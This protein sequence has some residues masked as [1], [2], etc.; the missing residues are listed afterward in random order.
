MVLY[1][2]IYFSGI[3]ALFCITF[4]SNNYHANLEVLIARYRVRVHMFIGVSVRAC[5]SVCI[6]TI[7]RVYVHAWFTNF[8]CVNYNYFIWVDACFLHKPEWISHILL[9]QVLSLIYF[10][11]MVGFTWLLE[12]ISMQSSCIRFLN[13]ASG[14]V[15]LLYFKL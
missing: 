14:Y 11:Q 8:L 7:Q 12:H 15:L 2:C 10:E 6:G 1:H 3:H 5:M 4:T 13:F 9:Y